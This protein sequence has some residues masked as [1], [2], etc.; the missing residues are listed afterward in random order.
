MKILAFVTALG[1]M[2]LTGCSTSTTRL[3]A[4]MQ[5]IRPQVTALTFDDPAALF[6]DVCP[7]GYPLTKDAL[8]TSAEFSARLKVPTYQGR[9]YQ[10]LIS[11]ELC[12]V[13]AFPDNNFYIIASKDSWYVDRQI[14]KKSYGISLQ[15]IN[16]EVARYTGQNAYGATAEV[17]KFR[18]T[19]L[20][21]MPVGFSTLP[22]AL[23]WSDA[24]P[25]FVHFGL[26][27]RIADPLFRER[28][29]DKK[30]SLAIRVRIGDL[31]KSESDFEYRA[32]T[33]TDPY[34]FSYQKAKIEATLL[35]A[36]IVDTTT[37][38]SLVHWKKDDIR[39]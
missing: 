29:K 6:N 25:S 19:T 7:N 33:I 30:I 17:T 24:T 12:K 26:P 21:I 32:A 16:E 34:G 3:Q 37:N 11:P 31:T 2:L 8:E 35:E 18:G 5:T 38:V 13:M 1:L 15:N 27:I 28:L 10:F 9:E 23:R 22:V 39:I 14:G 4:S 20:Q 36:W